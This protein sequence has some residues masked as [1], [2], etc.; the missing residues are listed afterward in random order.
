MSRLI[1]FSLILMSVATA[2]GCHHSPANT[3]PADYKD[4][5]DPANM[6]AMPQS[7]TPVTK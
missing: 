7:P 2:G 1:L 5:V 4:P 6:P 3:V